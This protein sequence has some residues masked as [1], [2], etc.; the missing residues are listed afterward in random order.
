M[1]WNK[2]KKLKSV[3]YKENIQLYKSVI[4]SDLINKQLKLFI[5]ILK[6]FIF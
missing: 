1:E 2:E 3:E 6:F 5:A 4:K